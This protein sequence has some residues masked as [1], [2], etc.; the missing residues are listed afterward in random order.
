MTQ[1]IDSTAVDSLRYRWDRFE[2]L[3]GDR[4]AASDVKWALGLSPAE[5]IAVADD[6][7]ATV[8]TARIAAGDWHRVD[9]LA[10][11]ETLNS[12]L[13]QV[14]AFRRLD[15]TIRGSSPVA[16]AG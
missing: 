11:Q 7:L 1:A 12:R 10:W 15:E 3:C 13:R 9:D 6:L 4:I 8:R 2:K 16:D 14:Q 5:R